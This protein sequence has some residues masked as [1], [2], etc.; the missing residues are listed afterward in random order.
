MHGKAIG[1]CFAVILVKL[2]LC[3]D[4]C[5]KSG[6]SIAFLGDSITYHGQHWSRG[7]VNLVMNALETLGVS[8]ACIPGGN[9]GNRSNDML[10]RVGSVLCFKPHWMTLSCGVNDVWHGFMPNHRGVS[11]PDYQKNITAILDR[12]EK[13]GVKVIV[14]TATGIGEDATDPRNVALEPYNDWLRS[15]ARKRH[16]PIADLRKD[17]CTEL[18][19]IRGEDNT[20]GNKVTCDG[21][22]MNDRGDRVM[23]R[24]ILRTMGISE[25]ELARVERAWD[26]IQPA[27][28]LRGV[29]HARPEKDGKWRFSRVFWL[30]R[31]DGGR[32]AFLHLKGMPQ[33]ARI[34]S[35]DLYLG[36]IKDGG[37][38]EFDVTKL[39][40]ADGTIRFDVVLCQ[41]TWPKGASAVVQIE[42]T[43]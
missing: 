19:R 8:A 22:H 40:S 18:D 24:G 23:A 7:Y 41:E 29:W 35:N 39:M 36:E 15:V 25:D 13:A 37:C 17:L 27:W 31:L 28:L 42:P 3:A 14:L 38:A 2:T 10:E 9:G 4:V 20:P 5:I 16:L 12:C 43:I 30:R 33:G 1:L 11:L 32:S 6:E 34:F 26:K 21:V